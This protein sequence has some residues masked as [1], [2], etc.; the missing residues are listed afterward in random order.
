MATK[1]RSKLRAI[2]QKLTK[3][4]YKGYTFSAKINEEANSEYY[5]HKTV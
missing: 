4:L 1:K 5:T 3:H 2:S